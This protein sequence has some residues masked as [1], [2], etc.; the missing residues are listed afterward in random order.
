[1]TARVLVIAASAL[2]LVATAS[3]GTARTGPAK[4][5]PC[6]K[7][8]R[9]HRKLP[10]RC[11]TKPSPPPSPT[12]PKVVEVKQTTAQ[13]QLVS[14]FGTVWAPS[15]E[16]LLRLDPPRATPTALIGRPIENVAANSDHVYALSIDA[17]LIYEV[18][19]TTNTVSRQWP[20]AE[21][22]GWGLVATDDALYYLANTSPTTVTRLALATGTTMSAQLP[23]GAAYGLGHKL[24][25]LGNSLWITDNA[26]LYRFNVTD[27]R[28]V[29]KRPFDYLMAYLWA[30]NGELWTSSDENGSERLDPQTGKV[31]EVTAVR[32]VQIAVSESGL[33]FTD[34]HGPTL[35]DPDSGKALGS[36]PRLPA[37]RI[38]AS[39]VAVLGHEAWVTYPDIGRLQR[40][41]F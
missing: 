13:F 40:I 6:A 27:L 3:P 18:D 17:R 33:W 1:M 41:Q 29:D 22:I 39:G 7:L 26:N 4:K 12:S 2:A 24:D 36:V 8:K 30:V 34:F 5:V 28:F 21:A 31:M 38:G 16:G 35:V 20:V 9:Q 19:P 14:A 25:V 11:R 15:P 10:A 37:S 32:A 23:G